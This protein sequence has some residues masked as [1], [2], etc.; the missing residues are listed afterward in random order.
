MLPWDDGSLELCSNKLDVDEILPLWQRAATN[1]AACPAWQRAPAQELVLQ[2]DADG[3]YN[4][5][6]ME[7]D[8]RHQL[9]AALAPLV[10]NHMKHFNIRA[11][12]QLDSSDVE[13]LADTLGTGIETLTLF[14]CA[15]N[16]GFWEAL[17][18]HFPRLQEIRLWRAHITPPDLA[19][20]L[21]EH[22]SCLQYPFRLTV[23]KE[24]P[25]Y[26]P[27]TGLEATL[28]TLEHLNLD[29]SCSDGCPYG[30]AYWL[31]GVVEL[32]DIRD[33]WA[34]CQWAGAAVSCVAG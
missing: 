27:A 25:H 7:S 17:A 23:Y 28:S 13:V 2:D 16:Q 30:S 26:L 4:S 8:Q 20:Y 21:A 29:L 9:F 15:L 12:L 10:G 34:S 19:T 3:E 33:C 6:L 11:S 22:C 24:G 18:Q 32:S 31:G 14:M 1:L 5:Q